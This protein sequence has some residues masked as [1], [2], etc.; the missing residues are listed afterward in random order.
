MC[1]GHAVPQNR[2][3]NIFINFAALCA[4]ANF[5]NCATLG[6]KIKSFQGYV[7]SFQSR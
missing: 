3:E 6:C 5:L 2:Q 4:A 7:C 1:S